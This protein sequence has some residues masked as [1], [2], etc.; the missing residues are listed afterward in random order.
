MT[1]RLF[2]LYLISASLVC[3]VGLST[4]SAQEY[5]PGELIVKLKGKSSSAT[6]Q[7][8]MGKVQ[9]K[10]N[11]KGSMTGLNMHRFALKAGE[12]VWAKVNEL[13]SDPLV[14]YAEPNYILKK[15]EDDMVMS[16]PM[17]EQTVY[18]QFQSGDTYTQNLANTGVTQAWPLMRTLAQ[19]S[20]RPIVA[21][22]DTGVDYNHTKLTSSGAMWVNAAEQAGTPGVDDDGNGFV[23]DIYGYN[24]QGH[25][26]TPMDDDSHSHGT[27]VAGIILGI[28]QNLFASSMEPARIRIMALKFLGA[29]GS[30]STSDAIAAIYYAVNNGAQVINNSWGGAGYSQSLHDALTY[31]YEH[32]VFIASAAGNYSKNNDTTDMYPANYPVPSQ[33]SVA[34][35]TDSDALSSFSNYGASSVHVA[36]PG[37]AITS[38]AAGNSYR[39][40]SGTS[41]ASP[42]VAGLAAVILREAPG[43]SGFQIKTLISNTVT[44][45]GGISTKVSSHGRTD[46]YDAIVAAKNELNTTSS[47]PSYKAEYRGPASTS[48][49]AAEGPKGCGLVGGG[50]ALKALTG[51]GSD[52][53]GASPSNWMLILALTLVPLIVWQVARARENS[54]IESRRKYERFKMNSEISLNVGG[55]QLTGQMSTISEG[56][57]SF[58]ADALLEKGGIVNIQIQSPDGNETV[59]VAGRIVWSEQNKAYGVQFNET[60]E[61]VASSIRG[62]TQSLAK[63]RG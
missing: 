29:D 4:A 3:F 47:Q 32:K 45:V 36:A 57:L 59:E 56:G 33:T 23:D 38:L 34:S 13:K 21:V 18:E 22:I 55:R 24:F 16:E 9:G 11:L 37:S 60:K 1:A 48:A 35:T 40:M 43:L 17:S 53:G 41:M 61:G 14:E 8:F 10:M 51:G 44:Y 6:A 31:A 46:V 63:Q 30:G 19:Y 27:H 49:A 7:Q 25:N 5:V 12:D 52:A 26:G 58:A 15:I 28:G 42:F 39:T 2:R 62:W 20:D 50:A 54:T